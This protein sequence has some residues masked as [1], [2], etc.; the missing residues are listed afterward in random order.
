M[1][2]LHDA[3]AARPGEPVPFDDL[4]SAVWP[5]RPPA[6]PRAALRNLVQ[7][8]RRTE[9]VVTE[10]HGYRLVPRSPGP[11]FGKKRL[12]FAAAARSSALSEFTMRAQ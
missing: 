4:V 1:R 6:N 3:L 8:L 10:P 7:R 12:T 11:W 2:A 5:V 9:Q